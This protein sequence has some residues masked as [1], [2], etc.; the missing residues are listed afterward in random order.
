MDGRGRG[1]GF[2]SG[3]IFFSV[4]IR[5]RNKKKISPLPPIIFVS[6]RVTVKTDF[7]LYTH[8]ADCFCIKQKGN[9]GSKSN[10]MALADSLHHGIMGRRSNVLSE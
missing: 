9:M 7:N 1:L 6:S 10:V 5:A 3:Q 2:S 4:K 8:W